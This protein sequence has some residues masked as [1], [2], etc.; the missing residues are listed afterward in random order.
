MVG[1]FGYCNEPLVASLN[2]IAEGN[3]EV[4]M[5]ETFCSVG[6]WLSS[7]KYESYACSGISS[8]DQNFPGLTMHHF[9]PCGCQFMMK[10][11]ISLVS[12]CYVQLWRWCFWDAK[13]AVI[14]WL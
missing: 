6:T 11:L 1:L 10:H 3:G 5:E 13:K 9:F 2:N 7:I 4:E 12:A 14:L 8:F